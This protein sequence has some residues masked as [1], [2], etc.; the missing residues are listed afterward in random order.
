MID[1][2]RIGGAMLFVALMVHVKGEAEGEHVSS[3]D[4]D[5][6][7]QLNNLVLAQYVH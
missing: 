7:N 1:A 6:R 2:V 4:R 3:V 5:K